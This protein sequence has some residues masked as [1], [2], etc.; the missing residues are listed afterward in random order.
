LTG[1]FCFGLLVSQSS[2]FHGELIGFGVES[3]GLSEKVFNV[4]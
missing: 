3:T 4:E 2:C 1:R